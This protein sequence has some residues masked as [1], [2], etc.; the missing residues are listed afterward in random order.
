MDI[1]PDLRGRIEV[2]ATDPAV[3]AAFALAIIVGAG[4]P[5]YP[6]VPGHE[7]DLGKARQ[8]A[9]AIDRAMDALRKL[10]P[11]AGPYVSQSN[12]FERDWQRSFWGA[13]YP[14][15]AGGQGEIRSRRP[16]LCSPQGWQ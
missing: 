8:D 5:A 9:G 11:D 3:L 1:A 16:V 6:G 12:F 14:R 15:V 13:N 2:A 7:P 10:V 4:P